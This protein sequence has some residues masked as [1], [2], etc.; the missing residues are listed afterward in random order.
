MKISEIMSPDVPPT[1]PDAGIREAR[2]NMREIDAGVLNVSEGNR[3][4]ASAFHAVS[5]NRQG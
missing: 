1:M 3:Q 2:L 5:G 4:V